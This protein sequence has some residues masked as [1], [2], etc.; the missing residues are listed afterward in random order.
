MRKN[1][2]LI[3]FCTG[4]IWSCSTPPET[5][6]TTLLNLYTPYRFS[7][8]F[9]KGQVKSVKE[10]TYWAIN[11]NG[12]IEKGDL[13]TTE[14]KRELQYTLDFDAHFDKDGNIL[15]CKYLLDE[16]KFNSW[17]IVI[18][19]GKMVEATFTMD[20]TVRTT[21][22]IK[23]A[24]GTMTALSYRMPDKELVRETNIVLNEQGVTEKVEWSN[25]E[26]ELLGY[27]LFELNENN[28]VV[29]NKRF[30]AKDSL[31]SYA[32]YTYDDKG[33]NTS[34]KSFDAEG[35]VEWDGEFEYLAYDEKGN[36]TSMKASND[37][38]LKLIFEREYEYY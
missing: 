12:T 7:P 18:V 9:L 27:Y 31:L 30:N 20:D 11:N 22:E 13:V 14:E 35:N 5:T 17:D 6:E 32:E 2:F 26:N 10:R 33:F 1:L 23:Y 24:N 4:L 19:D 29:G 34:T 37:G 28:M 25:P 36:W 38:E 8:E 15:Q 16:N 3:L 21:Q